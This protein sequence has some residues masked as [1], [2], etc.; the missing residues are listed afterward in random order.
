MTSPALDFCLLRHLWLI[1]GQI[2]RLDDFGHNVYMLFF[3]SFFLS[4]FFFSVVTI[5]SPM[6]DILLRNLLPSV[7]LPDV[8]YDPISQR[9]MQ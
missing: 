1:F 8:S 9:M 5:T 4:F 6:I 3:L 7:F 2:S